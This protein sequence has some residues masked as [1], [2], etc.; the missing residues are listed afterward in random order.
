MIFGG[1]FI[2][3]IDLVDVCLW[4]FTTFFIALVFYLQREAR[5]EGYPVEDDV[6]GKIESTDP[7]FFPGERTFKLMHGKEDVTFAMGPRDTRELA[8]KQ[9]SKIPGSP[10]VPTGNPMADGV[11]PSSYAERAEYPDL[12]LDGQ[13]R[14]A[15]LRVC[16][17]HYYVHPG[18]QSPI[19][20][21]VYCCD[22][23]KGG[24]VVDLWVDR[25]EAIFR[26]MEIETG[27]EEASNRVIV[28]IAFTN[29]KGGQHPKVLIPS[30][31][32][33]LLAQ[34][35]K[36]A[37]PDVMTRREEDQI[38]GY[39]GGGWLYATPDRIEPLL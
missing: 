7:L 21:S 24:E 18:Q 6:T 34:A 36:P 13:S 11:G 4:L 5:R 28:P 3:G 9:T 20:M 2:A 35:P 25:S 32:A 27:T 22:G 15:P 38:S 30:V 1:E 8:L 37:H 23:K 17:G 12:T 39:Y 19:G 10:F 14:I 33:E 29:K 31:T 16:E 26:Y